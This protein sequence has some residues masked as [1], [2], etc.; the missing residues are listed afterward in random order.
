M[1]VK[2]KQIMFNTVR[3]KEIDGRKVR[4]KVREEG[5]KK[6]SEETKGKKS[7]GSKEESLLKIVKEEDLKRN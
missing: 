5:R 2:L 7:G 3:P 4:R 6:V 1:F